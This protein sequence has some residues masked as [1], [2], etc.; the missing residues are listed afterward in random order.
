MIGVDQYAIPNPLRQ[1]G[2]HQTG[3]QALIEHA[4]AQ[5]PLASCNASQPPNLDKKLGVHWELPTRLPRRP[6]SLEAL[7]AQASGGERSFHWDEL[8]RRPA[9]QGLSHGQWWLAEKLARRGIGTA[10]LLKGLHEIDRKAGASVIAPEA[11][12]TASTRDRYLLSSLMEEA[13]SSSQMEGAATT[14]DVAKA[15]IRSHRAPRDRSEQMILNN[16]Q[17]MQRIRQLKDAP[18]TPQLELDLHRLVSEKTLDAPADAGRLRP[19]GMEVVKDGK[20]EVFLVPA[21]LPTRLKT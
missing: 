17:T 9:P 11:V 3:A 19:P 10:L 21:D 7:L 14:R 6:P 18:L 16:F 15:M 2:R 8:R 20:R 5:Q 1:Q 4:R 12:T 13:I